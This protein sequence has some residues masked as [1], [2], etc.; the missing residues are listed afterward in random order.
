MLRCS[1]AFS[2]DMGSPLEIQR[3]SECSPCSRRLALHLS[4]ASSPPAI[5]VGPGGAPPGPSIPGYR[6]FRTRIPGASCLCARRLPSPEKAK[7]GSQRARVWIVAIHQSLSHRD[8][9]VDYF[10]QLLRGLFPIRPGPSPADSSRPREKA[11]GG[12]LE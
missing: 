1:P 6:D 5:A 3:R 11:G 4:T 7:R 10:G 8:I 9:L 12:L 2:S